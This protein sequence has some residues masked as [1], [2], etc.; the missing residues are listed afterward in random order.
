M[1][2]QPGIDDRDLAREMWYALGFLDAVFLLF[3]G[4][5]F[6]VTALRDSH[7]GRVSLHHDGKAGDGRTRDLSPNRQRMIRHFLREHLDPRGFDTVLESDHLHVEYDP[8][9]GEEFIG[10]A[11]E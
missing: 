6:I 9:P 8:K 3:A 7:E 4:R 10:K 11:E 5:E 1:K 2:Y